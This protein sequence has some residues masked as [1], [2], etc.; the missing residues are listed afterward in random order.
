MIIN[1]TPNQELFH[2]CPTESFYG[3]VTSKTLW[4]SNSI[5]ANDPNEN[6]IANN[7]S[8]TSSI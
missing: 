2:Y 8:D 3:I 5:Y 1:S 7:I 6:K 4:L